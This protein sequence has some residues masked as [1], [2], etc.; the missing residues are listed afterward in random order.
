MRKVSFIAALSFATLG[1]L[2]IVRGLYADPP[3]ACSGTES[4]CGDGC[5]PIEQW[6]GPYPCDCAEATPVAHP[7]CQPGFLPACNT[8]SAHTCANVEYYCLGL[9]CDI[10]TGCAGAPVASGSWTDPGCP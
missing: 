7:I 4:G 2:C 1:L 3:M 9:P 6:I 5:I 10:P 8:E